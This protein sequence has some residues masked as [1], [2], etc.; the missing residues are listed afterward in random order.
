MKKVLSGISLL[1]A[2]FVAE[3]IRENNNLTTTHYKLITKN[4][5]KKPIRIAFIAD[6]HNGQSRRFASKIIHT[7][8]CAKPDMIIA[9]GD[10]INGKGSKAEM[11]KTIK[12][13]NILGRIAPL[14]ISNGNHEVKAGQLKRD[15]FYRSIKRKACILNNDVKQNAVKGVDIYGLDI[16]NQFYHRSHPKRMHRYYIPSL[17]GM[18]DK[19]KLN[20]LIAHNPEYFENYA[21]WGADIVLSGHYHGGLV[22]LPIFGGMI[23]SYLVP[24]PEYDYGHYKKGRS[25]M[26]ITNGLGAHTLK[27][28]INNIP[29][30]VI[31]DVF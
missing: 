7:I 12:L 5:L 26:Y 23:S 16:G 31:L 27:I 9:A 17:L 11:Q 18:P 8:K 3:C 4:K 30:V 21:K 15:Y 24:F 19:K 22:R 25:N 6:Y 2:A 14:Y 29:E 1:S 13:M 28:R 10:M 20:I